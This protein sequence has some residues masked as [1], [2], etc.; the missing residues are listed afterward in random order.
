MTGVHPK[1]QVLDEI[2]RLAT[3]FDGEYP[4]GRINLARAQKDFFSDAR[5]GGD[6]AKKIR[7][8]L[9]DW[10]RSGILESGKQKPP[11]HRGRAKY[12]YTVTREV[13]R[14]LK[15]TMAELERHGGDKR[16]AANLSTHAEICQLMNVE[17]A[18][19]HIQA[20]AIIS[21]L[22]KEGRESGLIP[23]QQPD[24]P[25]NP[26]GEKPQRVWLHD[27]KA[28]LAYISDPKSQI[29]TVRPRWDRQRRE[30]WFGQRL[31]IR[32]ERVPV[33]QGRILDAFEEQGWP[34]RTDDPLR[35]GILR[36]TMKNLQKSLRDADA[37][38]KFGG[39]GSGKAVTWR[40][41]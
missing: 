39:D 23:A 28:A 36:D 7:N 27:T 15:K 11:R 14:K 22:L 16:P 3:G 8:R 33:D 34:D 9:R 17:E 29:S 30:L 24:F 2:D 21:H 18:P 20:R 37:P 19:D 5:G 4:D 6:E 13:M 40:L 26:T 35:R 1:Q 12:E 31:C 38:I 10:C 41:R 25:I 32:F